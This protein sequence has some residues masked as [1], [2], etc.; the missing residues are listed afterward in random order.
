M[1]PCLC[2]FFGPVCYQNLICG[3]LELWSFFFAADRF[4]FSAVVC[5]RRRCP[6]VAF[7]FLAVVV[8]DS[9]CFIFSALW[10]INCGFGSFVFPQLE[11]KE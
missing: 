3:I 11:E 8:V 5:C 4:P 7:L 2:V 9:W 1:G 10:R 6:K